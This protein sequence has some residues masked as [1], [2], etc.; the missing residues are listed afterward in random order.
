MT[1][2]LRDVA[3]KIHKTLLSKFRKSVPKAASEFVPAFLLCRWSIFSH[4]MVAEKIR[5]NVHV[6][7]GFRNIFLNHKRHLEQLLEK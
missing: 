4:V 6:I 2:E 7:G 3:H 1:V 5:E